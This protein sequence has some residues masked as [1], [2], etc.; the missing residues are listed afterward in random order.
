MHAERLHFFD[1]AS[2][3]ALTARG[4]RRRACLTTIQPLRRRLTEVQ[5]RGKE[6]R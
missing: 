2:G 1:R 5:L 3:E 6:I 4:R